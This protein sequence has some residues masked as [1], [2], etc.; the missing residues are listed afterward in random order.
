[1]SGCTGKETQAD[2]HRSIISLAKCTGEK[3]AALF[4]EVD[5]IDLFLQDTHG[6]QV[7]D[8][9]T[10]LACLASANIKASMLAIID[11]TSIR[12]GPSHAQLCRCT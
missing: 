7:V 9:L 11:D 10:D 5:E 8:F 1:M 4:F 3:M 6:R 12:Y 2:D